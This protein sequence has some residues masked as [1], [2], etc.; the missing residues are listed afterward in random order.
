MELSRRTRAPT[1]RTTLVTGFYGALGLVA[2]GIGA[3]RGDLDLY[4]LGAP[5]APLELSASPVLTLLVGPMVG[6]AVGLLVVFLTRLCTHRFD[7][8]R[9]LHR[10]FRGLLGVLSPREIVALAV[11]SSIGEELLFRGAILPWL[12]LGWSALLFGALH[13]GPS[14]RFLPWT[15]SALLVGVLFG[16]LLLVTGNLGAPIAAHFTVNLMNLRYI[17]R[18]ELPE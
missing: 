10:D 9:Q 12:G 18:V 14:T 4:R 16:A 5:V 11:A 17:V 15:L 13:V 7:W 2:L 1:T 3:A 8:A 6:V